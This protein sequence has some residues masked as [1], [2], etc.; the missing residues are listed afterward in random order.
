MRVA[1][2]GRATVLDDS[3]ERT[4]PGEA[5]S[6]ALTCHTR[7]VVIQSGKSPS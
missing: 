2:I 3:L 6:I 4:P 1:F 5:T 7:N